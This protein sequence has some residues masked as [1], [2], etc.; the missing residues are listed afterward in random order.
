MLETIRE[1]AG[2]RMEERGEAEMLERRHAEHFLELAEQAE[3]YLWAQQTQAWLPRLAVEQPNFRAALERS[4]ST[5]DATLALRLAGALYSFWEIRGQHG[6]ARAWLTRGL[7][8]D[9]AVS[10]EWRAKALIGVGRATAWE[11]DRPAAIE[12]LQEAAALSG[13]LDDAEGV[14]RCLGFIGHALLFTGDSA[15]A[16]AVLNEGLDLSRRTG[17]RG[18]VARALNNAAAAALEERNFGR[19]REMYQE[20][21][22]I[23]Q[24]DGRKLNLAMSTIQLGYNDTLAGEYERAAEHLEEGVRLLT[25]IGETTWTP[26]AQRYIGLLA[27]LRERSLG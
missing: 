24:A 25:E 5:Q 1:Y 23:A 27:L 14:G 2:T 15:G 11:F 13:R 6:E 4:F 8:L 9:G 18:S 22:R 20:V 21:T 16:A 26:L 7:A 17:E 10:A 3:P 19:A 12:L